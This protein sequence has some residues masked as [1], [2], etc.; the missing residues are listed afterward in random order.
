[1]IAAQ[2]T[3]SSDIAE[4][5]KAIA[6]LLARPPAADFG[7]VRRVLESYGWAQ[8]RQSGSHLAFT[9]PGERTI[10]IPL[11]GHKVKRPYVVE[12][13]KRLGITQ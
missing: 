9:K 12:L 8:A 10:I 13:C 6:R 1:M 5:D 7:D 4:I 3:R 2:V 11:T